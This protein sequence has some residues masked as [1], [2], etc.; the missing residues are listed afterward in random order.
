MCT[1]SWSARFKNYHRHNVQRSVPTQVQSAKVKVYR[2]AGSAAVHI[3]AG[4]SN[5]MQ[6]QPQPP[7][8]RPGP[9]QHDVEINSSCITSQCRGRTT[10]QLR[11]LHGNTIN[12]DES[13][14]S[15]SSLN[16]TISYIIYSCLKF[17]N[18]QT[19][20]FL[21][22]DDV[23]ITGQGGRHSPCKSSQAT[24]TKSGILQA[25]GAVWMLL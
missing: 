3:R 16:H 8:A 17:A 1:N 5:N 18:S 10:V 20:L 14:P 22:H 4:G 13:I 24:Q 19:T 9:A 11:P 21:L 12:Q 25:M 7:S 2:T 15:H 6:L 23:D